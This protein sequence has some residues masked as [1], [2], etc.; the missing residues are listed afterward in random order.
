[1]IFLP[2]ITKIKWLF[3]EVKWY[4]QGDSFDIIKIIGGI[5]VD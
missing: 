3:Y 5:M 4:F 2:F 1:M